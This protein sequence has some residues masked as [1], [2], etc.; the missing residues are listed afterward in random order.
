MEHGN[1]VYWNGT[2][3]VTASVIWTLRKRELCTFEVDH[4]RPRPKLGWDVPST[5]IYMERQNYALCLN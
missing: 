4:V 1:L 3:L 2:H 5:W